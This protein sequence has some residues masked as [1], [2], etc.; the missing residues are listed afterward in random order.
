MSLHLIFALL[1]HIR[2][3]KHRRRRIRLQSRYYRKRR[4]VS[5]TTGL[6]SASVTYAT[7]WKSRENEYYLALARERAVH[8][9]TRSATPRQKTLALAA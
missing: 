9:H 1:G 2:A 3:A 5:L 8:V 7:P 6:R 4:G